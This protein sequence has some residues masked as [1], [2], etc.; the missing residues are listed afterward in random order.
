MAASV[1][2]LH[3]VFKVGII[4]GSQRSPRAGPQI[5]DFVYKTIQ[6][7]Q[8]RKENIGEHPAITFDHIDLAALNLPILN[9]PAIPNQIKS[10]EAYV[11]ERTRSWSRR[12]DALDAF[13]FV[14][15]QYNWSI[16]G[17]LKNALDYLLNEWNDKAA[18]IV[19]YG[20]R[21]G[22]KCAV[23]LEIVLGGALSMRLVSKT[24][25]LTFPGNQ[26]LIKAAG[27]QELGLDP[28]K[29][30]G[31]WSEKRSDII[32]AWDEL[33]ELLV[34]GKKGKFIAPDWETKLL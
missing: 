25:N 27:G 32:S 28:A 31:I 4:C 1:G 5:T 19:S 8:G 11:H 6:A 12:V 30:N 34:T 23:H 17:G 2:V 22:G 20:G 16:P 9:E 13:V 21:G 15:P 33:I 29:D 24:V 10:P 3:K 18:M 26:F 14:T 7:H